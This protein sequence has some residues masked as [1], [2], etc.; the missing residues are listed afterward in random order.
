M[1]LLME[2]KWKLKKYY[3]NKRRNETCIV[4]DESVASLNKNKRI[5]NT[6]LVL[7][8]KIELLMEVKSGKVKP[9]ILIET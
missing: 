6:E 2:G 5:N 3:N 7:L 1:L 9:L 8:I 4:R